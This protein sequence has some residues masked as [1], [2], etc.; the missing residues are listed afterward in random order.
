MK[1]IAAEYTLSSQ[2]LNTARELASTCGLHEITAKILLS[3]GVDTPEKVRKFLSPSAKNFLSPFLMRGMRELVDKINDAKR[4]GGT[5]VVYGDYD[6]DGIG[7]A[8]ILT[9]ALRDY[10]VDCI[11]YVPERAEGYGMSVAAL[12]K[13]IDEYSPELI[14]TV[15]CGVSNKKEVEYVLSR[16]VQIVVTDHHELPDVLPDCVVINPKINDDY[17]YDNLCGAGVAFKVACAL[18]G[19]KAYPLV[20]IAAVST[21]AD[22][23]P[24]IGENRD[25]VAE[26]LKRINSRPRDAIAQLLAG[27]KEEI[28]ATSLAFTVAPRINAA[29]RMGDANSALRLFTAENKAD[30]YDL[31]CKLNEY[32]LGRQQ[33]C[34][35]AYRRAKE[36]IACEGVYDNVIMLA[37]EE[38][39][40]GLVGIVAAKLAEE[41]NRP[42]IL[43]VCRG[44]MLKGS[45][46]TIDGVNIYEALKACSQYISEFGGHAQAAGV[47]VRRENFAALKAALDE[48][49]GANYRR[50]DFI[51]TI[52]VCEKDFPLD[53]SLA[54]ELDLLEPYG[55]GN[56]KPLFSVT[57]NK[58]SARPLKQGSPHIAWK[59]DGFELVWFG[60]ERALPVL[61]SDL[62]KEVVF[63]YN[64]VRFRG[65]E[66]VRGIVRDMVQCGRGGASTQLYVFRNDLMRLTASPSDAKI[67]RVSEKEIKSHILAARSECAYGL[68]VLASEIVPESF[69]ECLEG[70][71]VDYFRMGSSNVGNAVLVSPSSDAALNLYREIVY[72]DTPADF[73]ISALSGK[74][75]WVNGERC[76]YDSIAELETERSVLA[77]IY[78][79][80]R[81]GVCGEDSVSAALSFHSDFTDRQVVFA[82]EVFCEL[83][84]LRFGGGCLSAVSGKKSDL[85]NSRLY[86][87]VCAIKE[88]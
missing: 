39:N 64:V 84:L 60:G 71:D 40:T 87:A 17:P 61:A 41:F 37:D 48:Y 58:V 54:K 55:V 16:G 85:S 57:G 72:L 26:G 31:A 15:D 21:V 45:A 38:W 75:V 19:E 2:Q 30:I 46:R 4:C 68:A 51:P 18:L 24:L 53:L 79:G 20:E 3:R 9:S 49:V 42:V 86:R 44:D 43:F 25:I 82:I 88:K 28:T 6:A 14:V 8:S 27:K 33:A 50:D 1:K 22:S 5:V 69:Q 73:N 7:A 63:E 70:L 56:R 59:A 23:V 11:A 83:G 36:M 32:N 34:D 81:G 76:G 47:N 13:L 35:E 65:K 80:L 66:S 52:P 29:G 74:T 78:R 67:E 10:G 77:E 12:E 62:P